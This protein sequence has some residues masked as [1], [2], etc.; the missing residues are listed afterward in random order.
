MHTKTEIQQNIT[1]VAF[2]K[3][4][5]KPQIY[6]RNL[7]KALALPVPDKCAGYSMPHVCFLQRVIAM[8][9][10]NVPMENIADLLTK[11][12]NLL[13]LLKMKCRF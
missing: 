8:R 6:I 5:G 9:T 1:M 10:F 11:E 12:K 13:R 4:C 2:C 3:V 7:Q